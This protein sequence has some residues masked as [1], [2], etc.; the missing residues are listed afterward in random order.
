MN[1]LEEGAEVLS[2][3]TL[4]ALSAGSTAPLQTSLDNGLALTVGVDLWLIEGGAG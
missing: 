4:D 1:G 3:E 2:D